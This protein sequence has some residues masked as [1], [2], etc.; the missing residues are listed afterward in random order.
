MKGDPETLVEEPSARRTW[1]LRS[2]E[3]SPGCSAKRASLFGG[4]VRKVLGL[5]V[6]GL[7]YGARGCGHLMAYAHTSGLG[8]S[9]MQQGIMLEGL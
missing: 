2:V 4:S 7:R 5:V 1:F 3:P 9:S 8:L 6:R